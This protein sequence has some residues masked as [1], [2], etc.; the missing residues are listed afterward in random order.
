M[1]IHENDSFMDEV[2]RNRLDHEVERAI[3][4]ANV[5]TIGAIAG[6][7]DKDSFIRSAATVS[8]LRASYLK[9][10][11]ALE[12]ASDGQVPDDAA[13]A[14]LKRRREAYEEALQG[15]G[16]LRHAFKRGYFEIS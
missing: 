3:H 4:E 15:F 7:V 1:S 5:V 9:D 13:I 14:G 11:L 16:A 12:V 6:Q 10:V 8:R 2:G